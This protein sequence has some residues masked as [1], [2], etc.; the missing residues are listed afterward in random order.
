MINENE[1]LPVSLLQSDADYKKLGLSKEKV[2]EWE[3]GLRTNPDTSEFE[4]WYFDT[5]LEDKS[6][7]VITFFTKHYTNP[8]KGLVPM[9]DF[10]LTRPDG[11]N[12]VV[13]LGM[14]F[15]VSE[16]SASK[17]K[18]DVHIGKNYFSGD[19]SNYKI[20]VEFED[21]SC[22]VELKNSL[23]SWRSKTGIRR[24]NDKE[25]N[26]LIAVPNGKTTVT[27]NKNGEK[28]VL[29]GIGYHD[30]NWGTCVL[31]EI[32]HHWYWGR[33]KVGD[34]FFVLAAVYT[35]KEYG[36]VPAFDFLLAK[37]GKI[38]ADNGLFMQLTEK[39]IKT[40][41]ETGKPYGNTI[42]CS[43]KDGDKQYIISLENQ[44]IIVR[45]QFHDAKNGA[46]LRFSGN[47]TIKSFENNNLTDE[48]S[49]TGIWEMMYFGLPVNND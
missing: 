24:Y 27:L 21:F 43:Y 6:K 30:H 46:Y 14:K 1:T 38:I 5:E 19:L 18:C 3:D 2:E 25:F 40:D 10:N 11:K 47:V 26:W 48:V 16:F 22:D 35:E 20:H 45:D 12:D 29:K 41:P 42:E 13:R 31:S 9:V 49:E 44:D 23:V 37:D 33:G 4:W 34:Y 36:Y 15:P 39:N 17:E 28:E 32:I 8:V 7:L